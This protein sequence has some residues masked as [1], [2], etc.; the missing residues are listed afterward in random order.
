MSQLFSTELLP[1]SDRV[2]AWYW[3]A[4]QI[5][6]D[7][8]FQL[9]KS[10]FH[11]SIEIRH[12]GGLRLTRF[13][14][15]SLSFWKRPADTVHPD[16]RMCI[17]ITQM[18]GVRRYLQNG[19][20]ILLEPG[21][22]TVIDA[23]QP[24]SSTCSTD[25]VRLYLRV[26]RW[27]MENRLQMREIPLARGIRG[28]TGIGA[29]L[30][31]LSQ[32][33]YDEAELMKEEE[34]ADALDAYLDLLAACIGRCQTPLYS[35]PALRER[36]HRFIEAN[37]SE[38]TLGPGKVASAVGISVRHLHR[39]FS[40]SGSTTLGDY[41]RVRRLEQC[42]T[43][44]AN[45]RLREKKITEIAFFWGFSDSAHFSHSFRK[46]FGVSPRVF[47]EQSVLRD[48]PVVTEERLRDFSLAQAADG[49]ASRL[50]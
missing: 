4:Q 6:G 25:C 38:P 41:V 32:S 7:C 40:I 15:S 50:N 22:S 37:I 5:C 9:P 36:I 30:S 46:Q 3:N 34:S 31:R 24:W 47:R 23:G 17:V 19:V 49:R 12:V 1:P 44:L 26:P 43:D 16:T 28:K 13:S 8:R 27:M 42:R 11:G 20:E 39:L 29:A 35:R 18:S 48:Q 10:S 21:D 33:L 45:P 2:D 14:S